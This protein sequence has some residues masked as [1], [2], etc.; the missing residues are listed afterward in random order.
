M[1]PI[2]PFAVLV[3]NVVSILILIP[4][5]VLLRLFL[6]DEEHDKLHVR[7]QHPLHDVAVFMALDSTQSDKVIA[8]EQE[9]A[10]AI[11]RVHPVGE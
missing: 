1:H 8:F 7:L 6:L 2:L 10:Q 4:H 3:A 9:V 11:C 5:D